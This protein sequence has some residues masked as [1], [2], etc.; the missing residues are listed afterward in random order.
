[1]C[2]LVLTAGLSFGSTRTAIAGSAIRIMP[3][4]LCWRAFLPICKTFGPVLPQAITAQAM[5]HTQ[6]QNLGVIA[7][8]KS[9]QC[10]MWSRAYTC[11][12]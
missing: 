8:Q 11:G 1:M 5:T 2:L 3:H 9:H 12:A 7:G 6:W 4:Y 10:S